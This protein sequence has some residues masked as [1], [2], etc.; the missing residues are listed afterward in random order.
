MVDISATPP[1]VLE[2]QYLL[3]H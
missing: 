1:V 2:I 3:I